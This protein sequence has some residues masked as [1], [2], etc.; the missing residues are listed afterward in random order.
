MFWGSSSSEEVQIKGDVSSREG[1]WIGIKGLVSFED[2]ED[3]SEEMLM[4]L[5]YGSWLL[6]CELCDGKLGFNNLIGE[7]WRFLVLF[8]GQ[9]KLVL[10][11]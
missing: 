2:F 4:I 3:E 11:I 6:L 5:V 7:I 10:E 9:V 1:G 8:I